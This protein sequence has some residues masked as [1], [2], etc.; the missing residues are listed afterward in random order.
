MAGLAPLTYPLV[1]LDAPQVLNCQVTNIP[2]STGSPLQVIAD[3][4]AVTTYTVDFI[5]TTGD[6][7]GV[8]TGASG[9]E[10]LGCLIGGGLVGRS[11]LIVQPHSRVSLRSLTTGA[12]VNGKLTIAL[13]G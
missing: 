11:Y 1:Y 12:I 6:F 5:D 10:V 7:I 13:S 2:A 3:S 9:S 4:G 8:F